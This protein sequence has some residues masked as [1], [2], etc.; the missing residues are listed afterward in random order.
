[1][2]TRLGSSKYWLC[3][4]FWCQLQVLLN[5][6]S[7]RRHEIKAIKRYKQQSQISRR[8]ATLPL[9]HVPSKYVDARSTIVIVLRTINPVLSVP[10]LELLVLQQK[11]WPG[12]IAKN[13]FW[14]SLINSVKGVEFL[15]TTAFSLQI[16]RRR[17]KSFSVGICDDGHKCVAWIVINI[18]AAPECRWVIGMAHDGSVSVNELHGLD[19]SSFGHIESTACIISSSKT[20]G[21]IVDF[22]PFVCKLNIVMTMSFFV[23]HFVPFQEKIRNCIIQ[24]QET[25]AR[26]Y[27]TAEI[28]TDF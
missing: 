7:L 28:V 18:A 8:E 23:K 10:Y 9:S 4:T 1:M 5:Y 26:W 21:I 6:I 19:K 11:Q 17:Q 3:P 24:R 12:K 25:I 16:F 22:L 27:V 14:W 2:S 15:F 20:N 13:Q